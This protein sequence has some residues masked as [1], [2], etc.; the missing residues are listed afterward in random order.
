VSAA[1]VKTF[2]GHLGQNDRWS[3]R[4][5]DDGSYQVFH[6]NPFEGVSQPYA[7]DDRPASGL[8]SSA[9]DAEAELF[10]NPLFKPQA[11]S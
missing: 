10:R 6:D 9:E 1:V 8:F 3:I 5:R 11:P 2:V 4:R 7:S